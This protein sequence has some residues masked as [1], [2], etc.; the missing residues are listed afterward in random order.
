[1]KRASIIQQISYENYM[2][3][4]QYNQMVNII[5][6]LQ[7]QIEKQNNITTLENQATTISFLQNKNTQLN[8][9]LLEKQKL[10]SILI[11]KYD[12]PPSSLLSYLTPTLADSDS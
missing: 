2:L 9:Q 7:K 4:T 1:M 11:E 8:Q 5:Q 10:L 3:K 6:E 12:I